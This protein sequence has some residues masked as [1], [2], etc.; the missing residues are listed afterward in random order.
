MMKLCFFFLMIRRPPRSTLFPYTTLFRSRP[1]RPRTW[2]APPPPSRGATSETWRDRPA[3]RPHAGARCA[4]LGRE[5][6]GGEG[7]PR[8][9]HSARVH[10]VALR[11]RRAGVSPGG[12][13]RNAIHA[14]R[15]ARRRLARGPARSRIRDAGGGSR[16]HDTGPLGVPR[17]QLLGARPG[18]RLRRIAPA[19]AGV[20]GRG[21][22]SRR[23]WDVP[24]H[25]TRHRWTESRRPLDPRDGRLFRWA[26]RGR[27]RAVAAAR[28]G[29]ARVDG[30][31]RD[32]GGRGPLGGAI[33]NRAAALEPCPGG[34]ARLLGRVRHGAGAALAGA[35]PAPHVLG[36]RG[37][38]VL[39]GAAVRR[40][41]VL[42]LV[43]GAA[44]AVAVGR[45]GAHS[46]GDG[47]R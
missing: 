7:G 33:R 21:A 31:G 32:G 20:G 36:A 29:A 9:E 47:P 23:S 25:R 38:A 43:R 16:L 40:A 5:L 13:A 2:R 46:R 6:R 22:R 3:G 15:A 37:L 14:E 28:P 8:R 35:G 12:T 4:H 10:G 18:R 27:R 30:N 39:P 34:R 19:P 45:R 41:G 26:D 42:G 17:G 1:G 44:L 24:P 11:D